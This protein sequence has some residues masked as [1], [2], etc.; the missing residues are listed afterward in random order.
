VG[1]EI[2]E[3]KHFDYLALYQCALKSY[4]EIAD[5]ELNNRGQDALNTVSRAIRRKAAFIGLSRRH[6]DTAS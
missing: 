1:K 6:P 4:K 3:K 2:R 5:S